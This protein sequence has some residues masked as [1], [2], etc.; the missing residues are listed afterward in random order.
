MIIINRRRLL[1]EIIA[2]IFRPRKHHQ[3]Y[4]ISFALQTRLELTP[5]TLQTSHFEN[6]S[7]KILIITY[8]VV[9]I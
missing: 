7:H 9:K 6:C 2:Y 3:D 5:T 8:P 1:I 4:K